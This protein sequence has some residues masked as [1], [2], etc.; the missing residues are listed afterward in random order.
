[1]N[2]PFYP[3]QQNDQRLPQ[4]V[5]AATLQ[6]GR[7]DEGRVGVPGSLCGKIPGPSWTAGTQTDGALRSGRGSDEEGSRRKRLE[8]SVK[9]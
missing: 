7:A 9:G 8:T 5:R 6:G 1:M 4:E 2:L 3:S